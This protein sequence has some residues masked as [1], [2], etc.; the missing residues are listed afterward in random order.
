MGFIKNDF[1]PASSYNAIPF[2]SKMEHVA[3]DHKEDLLYLTKLLDKHDLPPS[4]YI[5]LMHIH[6]HQEEGNIVAWSEF[7]SPSM[8][9]IPFLA[10]ITLT[11]GTKVRGCHYL[12]D[13]KGDLQAFEYTTNMSCLDIAAYPAFVAEFCVYIVE[14]NLQMKFGLGIKSGVAEYGQ[15]MEIGYPEKCA[16]FLLRGDLELPKLEV[17]AM[18]TTQTQFLRAGAKLKDVQAHSHSHSEFSSSN[19][20]DDI[21]GV[22][23]DGG[24]ALGGQ[25]LFPDTD[26]YRVI[27]VIAAA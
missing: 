9:K 20:E 8:G 3:E 1:F 18:K 14:H 25:P 17:V 2:I 6:S 24:F 27:S 26:F 15:W 21:D 13:G 5:K 4:V 23:T 7:D 16:T 19:G 10:P 11:G 12:V 22:T